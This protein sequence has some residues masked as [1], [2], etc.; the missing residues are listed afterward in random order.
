MIKEIINQMPNDVYGMMLLNLFTVFVVFITL[1]Y[2]L[3]ELK[4]NTI[5]SNKMR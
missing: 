5:K 4:L 2:T 1:T 3:F